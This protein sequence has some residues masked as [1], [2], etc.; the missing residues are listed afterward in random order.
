MLEI[1]IK[2]VAFGFAFGH[3]GC[4]LRNKLNALDLI[5]TL[6]SFVSLCIEAMGMK[7][8]I[9]LKVLRVLRVLRA[10]E[11]SDKIRYVVDC[12]VASIIRIFNYFLLFLMLLF[13]YSII[14]KLI[15]HEFTH[16]NAFELY[17]KSHPHHMELMERLAFSLLS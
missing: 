11:I 6:I 5:V 3:P 7:L 15:N 9:H 2:M 13:I 16:T 17:P 10:L 1:M 14:G 8:P 12:L 4:Y